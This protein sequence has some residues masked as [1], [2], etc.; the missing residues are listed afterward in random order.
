MFLDFFLLLRDRDVPVT[1]REYL[2]LLGALEKNVPAYNVDDFYFLSRTI[3]VK[4]EEHLDL[5]DQIFAVYFKGI[6]QI[7]SSDILNIPDEWL[8]KNGERLF[9]PEELANIK[10]QGDL[11]SLID[12]MAELLKEQKERHQGGNKWIG[13]GGTSP[14]GAYGYN[15][16]GIRIGQDKSRHR[17]A[18]KVWDKRNFKDLSQDEELGTRNMKMALRKLRI[19]SRE[20]KSEEIDLNKT[21]RSTAKNSGMLEVEMVPSKKNVVKVLLLF[22]IGGSMDDHI[23]LCS[24]L[25]SAAKYE[26]KHL[27]FFYFHNCLYENVWKDNVRRWDDKTPTETMFNTFNNDYRVVF[28]GDASMSP[29]EIFSRMGSV[30]HYNEEPG[31]VWL[32]RM[33]DHFPYFVWLNPVAKNEWKYTQSIGM[34]QKVMKDRMFPLTIKGIEEAVDVLKVK[35]K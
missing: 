23:A 27:E 20:G 15:P 34:I 9:S 18:V 17:K 33:I 5:F 31:Q 6:E 22:D 26:F 16:E 2:D 30:E 29:Y 24:Q 8:R 28:V 25:F 3:L 12:R 35:G 7:K 13:T 32:E 10:S 4:H 1:L 11:E 14:F 21:I 19:L